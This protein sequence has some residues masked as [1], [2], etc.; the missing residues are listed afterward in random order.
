MH[1]AHPA[2][3]QLAQQPVGP[4]HAL[5]PLAEAGERARGVERGVEHGVPLAVEQEQLEHLA[6]EELVSLAGGGEERRTLS[7]RRVERIEEELLHAL[8][9]GGQR[10]FGRPHQKLS[11]VPGVTSSTECPAGSRK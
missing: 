2:P 6:A 8:V 1:H 10:L 5:A 3:A 11:H 9:P 7:S 4:D